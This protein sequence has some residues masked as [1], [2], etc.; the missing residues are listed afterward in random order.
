MQNLAEKMKKYANRSDNSKLIKT[1]FEFKQ[2]A[3]ACLN[4]KINMDEMLNIVEQKIKKSG[5]KIQKDDFKKFKK[6]IKLKEKRIN[7][8]HAYMADCLA[9]DIEYNAELEYLDFLQ[10]SKND[11][12]NPEEEILISARLEVGWSLILAGVL[13]EVVGTQ[14]GVPIIKQMGDFC[15]GSGIGYL[16]DEHLVNGAGEKK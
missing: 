12:K 1:M 7:H 11:L 2:E 4:A 6:L 10:K 5:I 16:M 14:L 8:K 13:A 3:E 9:Y 15:I